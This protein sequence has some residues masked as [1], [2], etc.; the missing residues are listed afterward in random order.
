MLMQSYVVET[1]DQPLLNNTCLVCSRGN[2]F[3]CKLQRSK[4]IKC[5]FAIPTIYNCKLAVMQFIF[6][7]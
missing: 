7:E 4:V 2:G 3:L 6:D 5:I 1:V